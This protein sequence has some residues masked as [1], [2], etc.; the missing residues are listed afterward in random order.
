VAGVNSASQV[1]G[2]S[3]ANQPVSQVAGANSD[4]QP[5]TAAGTSQVAGVSAN[6]PSTAAGTSQVAEVSQE[7]ATVARRD[8]CGTEIETAAGPPPE[9]SSKKVTHQGSQDPSE[10]GT[11]PDK[12]LEAVDSPPVT[13][14]SG[15]PSLWHRRSLRRQPNGRVRCYF[16]GALCADYARW[17]PLRRR[18]S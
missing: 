16:C 17:D 18:R 12:P 2:V 9:I 10:F 7:A 11:L 15:S 13:G 3:S 4:S 14:R 5:A 1:A 6:Q 8:L